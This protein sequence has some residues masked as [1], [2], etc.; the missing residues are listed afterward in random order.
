VQEWHPV[1]MFIHLP[2]RVQRAHPNIKVISALKY[3]IIN[4]LLMNF[5]TLLTKA[6]FHQNLSHHFTSYCMWDKMCMI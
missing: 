4:R 1:Y 5:Y 2:L 6:I 3:W